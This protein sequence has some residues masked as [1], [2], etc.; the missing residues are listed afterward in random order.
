MDRDFNARRLDVRAF[1]EAS[2]VLAGQ[3]PVQVHARLMAEAQGHGTQ[4]LVTW[5]AT[6]EARNSG[7]AHP[8]VWVHLTAGTR[9]SL[10]C[11][12]CLLPAE[13]PV[14]VKRSFRF[15][16]DE[17]MAAAQDE[18]SEED[19]LALSRT[20]DLIELVED[21]LLMEMPLAPCHATCPPIK[22]AVADQDFEASSTPRENPFAALA[23]LKVGKP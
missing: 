1:A 21:E 6:G 18:L 3:E 16:A 2:G 8:E 13:V 9:L 10:T 11:Q 7:H 20:F 23:K 22:L 5:S 12:R 4:S 14:S 19:V 17:E 15:A